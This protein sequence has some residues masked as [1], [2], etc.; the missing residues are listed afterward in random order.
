MVIV[1]AALF[2]FSTYDAYATV[3]TK[4]DSIEGDV[5]AA[6]FEKD[7]EISSFQFGVNIPAPSASGGGGP[8][9]PTFAD[10]VITKNMDK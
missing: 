6:G 5:T 7:I 2:S 4:I 9:H 3:F 8:G 10:L 1:A